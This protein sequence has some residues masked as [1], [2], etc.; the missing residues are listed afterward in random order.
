M[1]FLRVHLTAVA[2]SFGS[3]YMLPLFSIILLCPYGLRAGEW[4]ERKSCSKMNVLMRVCVS[5]CA[6]YC[7]TFA[8]KRFV[9]W[10]VMRCRFACDRVYFISYFYY[11]DYLLL[12]R[13]SRVFV[14]VVVIV[15]AVV[16]LLHFNFSSS[17]WMLSLMC[18]NGI[19][20]ILF[21]LLASSY[22]IL[23]MLLLFLLLVLFFCYVSFAHYNEQRLYQ[24]TR[25]MRTHAYTHIW[26]SPNSIRRLWMQN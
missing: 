3:L 17:C 23:L 21:S 11:C 15:V 6:I 13:I 19:F 16:V 24:T 9:P 10:N 7:S 1:L 12:I 25:K 18:M 22:F 20:L 4:V 2:C 26:F 8:P 14:V 5:M